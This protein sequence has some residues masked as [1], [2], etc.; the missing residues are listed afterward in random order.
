MVPAPCCLI[1]PRGI[2]LDSE[3]TQLDPSGGPAKDAVKMKLGPYETTESLGRGG[4]AVVYK[5]MQQSLGRIVAIKV[6]PKEFSRD[7]QFVGR[8]H[9]EA[10]SVAKL[11][12]PNIIQIIDKGEAG[13][14]C[15][16]VMEY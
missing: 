12:H 15:Y 16:F 7:R 14:T 6:L 4:M 11:N 3:R 2:V 1:R 13:G 8:F 9:R 10:E 5:G